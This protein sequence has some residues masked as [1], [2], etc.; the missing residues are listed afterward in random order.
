M[1]VKKLLLFHKYAYQAN[2]NSLNKKL[3]YKNNNKL[4]K[5]INIFFVSSWKDSVSSH[6]YILR[7][8]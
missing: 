4:E 6:L 8:N 5:L 7:K 2:D 3:K 1:F